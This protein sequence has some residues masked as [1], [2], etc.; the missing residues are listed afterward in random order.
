MGPLARPAAPTCWE[1]RSCQGRPPASACGRRALA[2]LIA[3]DGVL[4]VCVLPG[5]LHTVRATPGMG[6]TD[7]PRT[8]Q[9]D[10]FS[11]G[12]HSAYNPPR[13]RASS[14]TAPLEPPT[15]WTGNQALC[16]PCRGLDSVL[17]QGARMAPSRAFTRLA[18]MP[19]GRC[20]PA[21]RAPAGH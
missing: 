13:C 3:F 19:Q 8:T 9:P 14:P 18:G 21:Q 11:D 6:R 1:P 16:L 17:Q 10:G 7:V 5:S 12:L 15:A 4:C 20:D 2:S